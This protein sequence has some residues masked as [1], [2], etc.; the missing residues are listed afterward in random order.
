MDITK[1]EGKK[2]KKRHRRRPDKAIISRAR[3]RERWED[4]IGHRKRP[5]FLCHRRRRVVKAFC[6]GERKKVVNSLHGEQ[7]LKLLN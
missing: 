7:T 1:I 4:K 5:A 2:E 6:K 3:E